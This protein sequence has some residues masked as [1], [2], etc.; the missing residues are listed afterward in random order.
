MPR[1]S[2]ADYRAILDVLREA[3]AVDGPN[4][5]PV[6]VLDAL[7]RLVPCNVASYHEGYPRERDT[8]SWVGEP[9]GETNDDIEAAFRR[10]WQQARLG[11]AD[12][13]RKISD[14]LTRREYHRLEIY[15]QVA[16]PLGTENFMRLWLELHPPGARFEFDRSERDFRERDRAV[17]DVLLPH[18]RQFHRNALGRRTTPA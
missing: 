15:Q 12:G 16:R 10:Y 17:L 3:A 13:A 2:A 18:L 11:P 8:V 7:R 9:G 5:F 14:F 4:P 6:P 1:V